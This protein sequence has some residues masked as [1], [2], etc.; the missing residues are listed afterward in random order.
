MR[1]PLAIALLLAGCPSGT[2][3]DDDTPPGHDDDTGGDDD[4]AADDDAVDDDDTT[5][6]PGGDTVTLTGGAECGPITSVM[7]L[8]YDPE[9]PTDLTVI[10]TTLADGCGLYQT[11]ASV[12]VDAWQDHWGLYQDA[13]AQSDGPA[14]CANLLGLYEAYLSSR[15]ALYAPASC[16]VTITLEGHEPGTYSPEA[17]PG[18]G[19]ASVSVQHPLTADVGPLLD[20]FGG[21]EDVTDWDS[22]LIVAA[23]VGEVQWWSGEDWGGT[24]GSVT[25][26]A[27]PD[28]SYLLDATGMTLEEAVITEPGTLGFHLTAPPCDVMPPP[29]Y[30][31]GWG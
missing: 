17:A 29:E 22:W 11:Y 3:S 19:T 18:S 24:A 13:I 15:A 6:G 28:G 27:L 21:C 26:D 8:V 9:G 20:A 7:H 23:T 5:D 31:G 4:A 10:A 12:Y 1:I 14:A 30:L 25:L 16:L 2:A